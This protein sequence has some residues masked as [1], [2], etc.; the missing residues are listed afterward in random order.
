MTSKFEFWHDNIGFGAILD[1]L[2]CDP[3]DGSR[4]DT[5]VIELYR[6]KEIKKIPVSLRPQLNTYRRMH[7]D[8]E[9]IP[10]MVAGGIFIMP[11][12]HNHIPIFR[13]EPLYTLMSRPQS[14]HESLIVITHILPESPFNECETVGA[15]D[16]LVALNNTP[17]PTLAQF[18]NA[19]D[20]ETSL[21]DDHVVTLRMRDG[22][23]ASA[24][25]QQIREN[26]DKILI[27]YKSD[28]YVGY[29]T[30]GDT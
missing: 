7:A 8:N 12:L 13:R 20:Y 5:V 6:D 11:L 1:R 24:T 29:R 21:S 3:P 18:K 10:Y 16:V 15:G 25:N 17:T 4:V 19:W 26:N 22:S 23:L 28:D 2:T 27:E 9:P 14:R 30:A